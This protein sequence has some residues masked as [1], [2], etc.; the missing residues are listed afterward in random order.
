MPIRQLRGAPAVLSKCNNEDPGY[1][2]CGL[3][4]L[5]A[6]LPRRRH[7]LCQ[8]QLENSYLMFRSCCILV[9]EH[10]CSSHCVG[11]SLVAIE[12]H[13]CSLGLSQ[14]F[15][16][17]FNVLNIFESLSKKKWGLPWTDV[18]AP[19][20]HTVFQWAA[21]IASRVCCVQEENLT[22]GEPDIC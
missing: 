10:L 3:S 7:H 4:T 21:Q 11:S 1:R 13:I 9:L 22:E 19:V 8:L 14:T 6:Q 17:S 15:V 2:R 5:L 12:L 16:L 18:Q 20:H